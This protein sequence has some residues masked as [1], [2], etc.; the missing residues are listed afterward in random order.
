M[1]RLN[2]ARL[3]GCLV[4]GLAAYVL[5]LSSPKRH[6]IPWCQV[7][8]LPCALNRLACQLCMAKVM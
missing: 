4:C 5:P 6:H 8:R 2:V 1:G 3:R 7:K